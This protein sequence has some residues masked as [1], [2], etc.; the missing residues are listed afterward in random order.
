MNTGITQW[1]LVGHCREA[2]PPMHLP[3]IRAAASRSGRRSIVIVAC[4]CWVWLA[5][6]IFHGPA[7]A[8]HTLATADRPDGPFQ[9]AIPILKKA[10][11][12]TSPGSLPQ[13][14]HP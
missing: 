13:T 11:E 10:T 6:A 3:R 7:R 2:D 9:L 8:A 5:Q 12:A 4:G 1:D 14:K